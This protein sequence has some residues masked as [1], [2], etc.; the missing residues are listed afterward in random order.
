MRAIDTNILVRLIARDDAQQTGL[1]EK[2]IEP[3]AWVSCLVLMESVWVLESVYEFKRQQIGQVV[4]MLLEHATLILQDSPA[5]R[6][7]LVAFQAHTGV[8][9]TDCLIAAI[10]E[11]EGHGPVATFDRKMARIANTQ[12]LN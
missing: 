11:S 2:F 10:A 9:F 8:G 12:R 1:A 5:V 4:G 6:T 3:G 7:A